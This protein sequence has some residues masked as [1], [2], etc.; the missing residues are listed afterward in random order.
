M[1]RARTALA[2]TVAA[3]MLVATAC[4]RGDDGRRRLLDRVPRVERAEALAPD[5]L[6]APR[7]TVTLTADGAVLLREFTGWAER[8]TDQGRRS[9]PGGPAVDEDELRV[10]FQPGHRP[11]GEVGGLSDPGAKPTGER[12]LPIRLGQVIG[13]IFDDA[14]RNARALVV[15]AP[16][17]RA[18][19]LVDVLTMTGG[20]LAVAHRGTLRALRIE[21]GLHGIG[22][23]ARGADIGPEIR[24]DRRGIDVEGVPDLPEHVPWV[25]GA[26]DT[27]GLAAALRE[28]RARRRLTHRVEVDLLVSS[29]LGVQRLVDVLVA[30]EAIGVRV[31][32]LG[33]APAPGSDEAR[34]RGH[35]IVAVRLG[36]PQSVG[37]LDRSIIRTYIKRRIPQIRACYVQALTRDS[38]LG[39]TVSTQ[40]FI[41]PNGSVSASN[42]AGVEPALAACIA[43]V[44]KATVFPKPKGGGGVQ[45]NFPFNLRN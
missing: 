13:E 8:L 42:A 43:G 26:V 19:A 9:P 37:D 36:Q 34:L 40:F 45:V 1:K 28:V 6:L 23:W 29:D 25:Q 39:G 38:S 5:S 27:E 15:A 32:V 24:V 33:H 3:V 35:R 4:G 31:V 12:E 30:L 21:F 7:F 11:A 18:G 22:N 2:S 20:I 41:T 10:T 16:A 14:G 44:I 17:A